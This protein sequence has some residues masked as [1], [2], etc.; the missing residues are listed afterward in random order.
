MIIQGNVGIG[1][2]DPKAKL[3]V[4][5]SAGNDTGVWAQ[6]SD[7]R[8]KRDI[9][10]IEGALDTVVQLRGVSYRWKDP[11][12]DAEYGRTMGLVAQDVEKVVPQWVKTDADGMKRVEPVGIDAVLIEAIKALKARNDALEARP[13]RIERSCV[14]AGTGRTARASVR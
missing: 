5:G 8:L 14:A 2:T 1:T 6:V 9:A 13:E 10:P 7:A 4:A 11:D 12:K 3:H